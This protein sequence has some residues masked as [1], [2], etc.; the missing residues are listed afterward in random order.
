MLAYL[1]L[2]IVK[3]LRANISIMPRKVYD[4][5]DLPPLERCYFDVHLADITK[6]KPLGRLND[7]HI[8]VNN[9]FGPVILLFWILNAI[10]LVLLF[11]EDVF[12]EVKV[13]LLI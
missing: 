3:H 11:W 6:K 13:L 10:L 5:L 9:N 1:L 4:M 12:L 8:K 7:V 2:L